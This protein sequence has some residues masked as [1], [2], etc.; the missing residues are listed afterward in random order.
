MSIINKAMKPRDSVRCHY[1]MRPLCC[2]RKNN[3]DYN[4]IYSVE[5]EKTA[6]Q[7]HAQRVTVTYFKARPHQWSSICDSPDVVKLQLT[8]CWEL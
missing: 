5:Q 3:Q 8:T 6:L 1:Y 7:V 4:Q 2:T